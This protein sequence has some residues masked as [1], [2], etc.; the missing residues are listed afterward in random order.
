MKLT[1]YIDNNDVNNNNNKYHYWNNA[2][3][4]FHY[5]HFLGHIKVSLPISDLILYKSKVIWLNSGPCCI[6]WRAVYYFWAL[7]LKLL[8][9]SFRFHFPLYKWLRRPP[10]AALWDGIS[11][12]TWGQITGL[13]CEQEINLIEISRWDLIITRGEIV[14]HWLM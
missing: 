3:C 5:F 11:L 13:W 12:V 10:V 1:N 8:V 7:F 2:R 9:Q 4:L 14:L 6:N